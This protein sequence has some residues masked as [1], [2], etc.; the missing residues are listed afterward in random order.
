MADRAE[1][2]HSRMTVAEV[3]ARYPELSAVLEE[4]HM[5][6]SGCWAGHLET[7]ESVAQTYGIDVEA[8]LTDLN[9]AALMFASGK[10]QASGED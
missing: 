7:L 9:V 3:L 8:L 10:R 1:F 5:A 2:L 4:Y 6:C